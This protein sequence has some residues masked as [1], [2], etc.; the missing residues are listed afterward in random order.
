MIVDPRVADLLAAPKARWALAW[1]AAAHADAPT[2]VDAYNAA[3]THPKRTRLHQL[4]ADP[5]GLLAEIHTRVEDWRYNHAGQTGVDALGAA[6][7]GYTRIATALL[8]A[9]AAAWWH[10]PLDLTNQTWIC[11]DPGIRH[12][13]RLPFSSNF[14]HHWD[15]TAPAA[16]AVTSTRL[17]RLPA[18]R[19]LADL[20]AC[21]RDRPDPAALSAWHANLKPDATVYEIHSPT[22]WV[23]LVTRYPSHRTDLCLAPDL[24]RR[25][26]AKQLIWTP[27]WRAVAKDYDGVHLSVAGWLTA[28]SQIL[29]LPDLGGHTICEGWP[30]ESTGWFKPVFNAPFDRLDTGPLAYGYGRPATGADHDL[31]ALPPAVPWW[32]RLLRPV[33]STSAATL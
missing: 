10:Q 32:R 13:R 28:T 3:D 19:L 27:E 33:T 6:P 30:A 12:G 31:T 1:L 20:N 16:S 18:T 8:A 7:E 21:P 9:P 26:P 24:M 23:T 22:D 15:A 11:H 2:P 14:G 4:R 25:W 29:D 17:P 5:A